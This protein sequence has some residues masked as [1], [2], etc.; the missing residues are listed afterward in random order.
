MS[1]RVQGVG[2]RYFVLDEA[3]RLDLHGFT[4]NLSDGRSVE[5][6]AEGRRTNLEA[7]LARLRARPKEVVYAPAFERDLEQPL[8]GAI[9]IDPAAEV[10]V[11]EGNYLLLDTPAWRAVRAQLDE[12]WYLDQDD[13]LRRQ[14]LVDRHVQ[15]GKAPDEARAWVARVDDDNAALVARSKA[16]A[17][18]V[19]DLR[20]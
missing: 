18:R 17:D 20:S 14:R 11:T 10:I 4:R 9:A 7:L 1:G 6:V 12:V 8:A 5:V 3:A 13:D 19:V 16:Q 15:F 2:F